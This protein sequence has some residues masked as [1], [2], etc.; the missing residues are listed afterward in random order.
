M[1]AWLIRTPSVDPSN[2]QLLTPIIL[3]AFLLMVPATANS[4]V[5]DADA[6]G[7]V[8]RN[9]I[10]AIVAARNT[11]ATGPDDPRDAD[12]D[13]F[14]T[15]LDG[16]RCVLSCTLP[17]CAEPPS[18]TP[19]V[20][21]AGADQTVEVGDTVMLD[22]SGSSDADGDTLQFSWAFLTLPGG[23]AAALSGA[24]TVAPSFLADQPGDYVIE[25]V[26]SDGNVSSAPDDVVIVTVPGNTAPVADAGPDDTAFVGTTVTLDGSGSSDVDGD[27]LTFFWTIA[28]L[29]AGSVA[30]L[31]DPTAVLPTFTVDLPGE[32]VVE[33]VVDDGQAGSLPD[34]VTITTE[35]SPPVADAGADQAVA[36][37]SLVA[38]DGSGS[39]DVDGDPLTYSWSLS[40]VPNGSSATL[41]DT[42]SV[43]PTFV[44]DEPG[45]YVAQLIVSGGILDSAPDTVVISTLNTQPVADAGDDQTVSVGDTV[46]LDGSASSD[47]DGDN[48]SFDWTLSVVPDSS[49]AQ[50]TGADT[51]TPTFDAD[52]EGLFVAQLIVNDGS[53]DSDPD[54]SR[55]TVEVVEPVDSDN[56]GLTDDEEIALGT[57]PNNPD[58]DGDGLTD[59]EEVN[60]YGT[61][62]LLVDTD[63]DGFT[64]FEEIE[65][66]SDATDPTSTPSGSIPPDP[67]TVAP[68]LD[69]RVATDMF[70]A[71]EFL[72]EGP[73][74]IQTGVADGTIEASQIAVIRGRV[75]DRD[76]GPISAVQVSIKDHPEYGQTLTRSDGG[77]DLA[78]NGGTSLILKYEREAYLAAQRQVRVPLQDFS[79]LDDVVLVQLDSRVTNIDLTSSEAIQVA[80]GTPVIDSDGSRQATLLFA[81]G[82][83]ATMV[84]PD[85]SEQPLTSL[86]VRATEYTVGPNGPEAMPGDLPPTSQYTYAVE[87]SVDQAQAAGATD[88][89]FTQPVVNYVENFLG[90]PTGIAVPTAYYDRQKGQWIPS[91]NG[92]V[93]GILGTDG[94]VAAVD[95]DG[96]GVADTGAALDELGIT[97]DERSRLA[98]LYEAG[99]SLWRVSLA[100]F[101]PWDHNWPYGPPENAE[102]PKNKKPKKKN[103]EDEFTIECKSI[104]E[105]ENQI[106]GESI[107]IS[108]TPFSLAYRSDRNTGYKNNYTLDIELTGDTVPDGLRLVLLEVEIAGNRYDWILG[109]TPNLSQT[110]EWDGL[111]AFGRAVQGE[112]PVHVRIGFEYEAVY[113][114]PADLEQS[115]ALFS[116]IPI[117]SARSRLGVVLWQEF[118]DT[119]GTFVSQAAGLGGWTLDVQHFYDPRTLVLNR[120]DGQR[121][122]AENLNQV[123]HTTTGDEIFDS[124]PEQYEAPDGQLYYPDDQGHQ[125]FTVQRDLSFVAIVGTGAA[126]FGGDGGPA[127]AALLN[128]PFDVAAAPDGSLYIADTGNFRIRKV[129]PDGIIETVAGT[130]SQAFSGEGGPATDAE[131]EGPLLLRLAPDGALYFLDNTRIRRIGT[132]GR[133]A[134]VAGSG[135]QEFDGDGVPA[136]QAAVDVVDFDLAADGAIYIADEANHRIRRVGTDGI[137]STYAGSGDYGFE[138]DGGLAT[139]AWLASPSSVS[140]GPDSSVYIADHDNSRIR[141]VG[142]DG[143]ITTVAGDGG[144]GSSGD[145]G[146]ATRANIIAGQV[147]V[148]RN[149]SILIADDLQD[150]FPDQIRVVSPQL[151][152]FVADE[153]VIPSVDGFELYVFDSFGRHL[154]TVN[155]LTGSLRY[156]FTY[157]SSGNLINVTDSNG[158]VTILERDFSIDADVRAVVGPY[159]HRTVLSRSVSDLL[160]GVEYPGGDTLAMSYLDGANSTGLLS[161]FTNSRGN[162]TFLSYDSEG[163]LVRD[164]DPA[165]GYIDL[166][167]QD[168]ENGSEVGVTSAGGMTTNYAVE[169]LPDSLITRTTSYPDGSSKE[170]VIGTDGVVTTTSSNG[171]VVVVRNGPDPRFGMQAFSVQEKEITTQA[172]LTYSVARNRDVNLLNVADP[173]TV[174]SMIDEL[175]INGRTYTNHY[176]SSTN[177]IVSTSPDGRTRAIDIDGQG[178]V[179]V[180]QIGT[181]NPT[182]FSYDARGRMTSMSQ[183]SGPTERLS[184]TYDAQS[185]PI[186]MTGPSNT[187][188]DFEYDAKGRIV[189]QTQSPGQEILYGYDPNDNLVSITPPGRPAH[190]FNYNTL[191]LIAEYISPNADVGAGDS[192]TYEYDIDRRLTSITHP[193][194]R[195]A[196]LN[197]DSAGRLT[198][199]VIPRGT[200][201]YEYDPTTGYLTNSATPEG[202]G[203][204]LNF[205]SMLLTATEWSGPINGL[206]ERTYDA[207]FMVTSRR[208]SGGSGISFSYSNDLLLQQAGGL[209]IARDPGTGLIV[210]TVLGAVIDQ[211]QYNG[212]GEVEAYSASIAGNNLYSAQYERDNLGRISSI[213]EVFG[214]ELPAV[215]DY[216][217]GVSNRLVGVTRDGASVATYAYDAN[218]NRLTHTTPV[219]SSIGTYD[220]KDRLVQYDSTTYTYSASG[221]LQSKTDS[222]SSE[223]TDYV[224]DA[225]GNLLSVDLPDGTRIEYI[226]DSANRRVGKMIDG[227]LVGGYL[228]KDAW[229]PIAQLDDAGNV[230]SRFVYASRLHVPDYMIRDGETY[231]IVSDHLGSPR[232]VVNV[233]TGQIAQRIDYD[234]FGRVIANTNP[235]FQP[236]GFAGGIYD[237]DTG[238]V[239]FGAD[240]EAEDLLIVVV[241]AEAALGKSMLPGRNVVI[242]VLHVLIAVDAIPDLDGAR[243]RAFRGW[244]HKSVQLR[245]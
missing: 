191:D 236:F 166:A 108:G 80:Q 122:R 64:D 142:A 231:R 242:G 41:S 123:I 100:H 94:G 202:Q 43:N 127:T 38:L 167:K 13:G 4:I 182:S 128:T 237:E 116:G 15:I 124:I 168:L 104:V 215:V 37:G 178:R 205:D 126:G 241:V 171:S 74:A 30:S 150:D 164:Q 162:T 34:F 209:A 149:G 113:Q 165:G 29:P 91:M 147:L 65:A 203:L 220:N 216:T 59:G 56:D 193:D 49:V 187:V 46:Q 102:P 151:P 112:W 32:Y 70:S 138:G 190:L 159:G 110:F 48:L 154:R 177:Q 84:M 201:T 238:L 143:I 87:F 54:T 157:D 81:Q 172:G 75:T 184:L 243:S 141:R 234:E 135:L 196:R 107:P 16:R 174:A 213:T 233:A 214:T 23:S 232:I 24:N 244:Q 136:P 92:R 58:T 79:V 161:E 160:S 42:T 98:E 208:V 90:F 230:V 140:V 226:V 130:G 88:V 129:D 26:V 132:D 21:D 33:L 19:P 197:Y 27:P 181:L 93:I 125:V 51:A 106:L 78:V 17:Y 114:E 6:D 28:T 9:D 207:N 152:G 173:L 119:L 99:E 227:V 39:F 86:A 192:T 5:C 245:R 212:F 228:Y 11:P 186:R 121:R 55:V 76:G 115:F 239:R 97:D 14:I 146:P 222:A 158:N 47:A 61:S 10:N 189:R 217:Y 45:S 22:G 224:Y 69:M 105:V 194:G 131:L 103:K 73:Q 57:D 155:A 206:V 62:P 60:T 68:E 204:S 82:T 183:G 72:Y 117:T 18:N 120:G 176:D 199:R 134:T 175:T 179:L 156:Q 109:A 66:G 163:L 25:L 211:V 210:G 225:L 52:A 111:D 83:A 229:N 198:S 40:V 133:I 7:D 96:D 200:I 77:Y 71:S 221:E 2:P 148:L 8:D 170:T 1:R 3:S 35:N 188:I 53:L 63:D 118:E 144:Y 219:S 223:S 218:G 85:G 95:V 101:S 20:A 139:E 89:R 153:I 195:I 235:G 67:R 31:S 44:A 145:G 185:N 137:I 240:D 180:K 12:G 169:R 50:L 36:L